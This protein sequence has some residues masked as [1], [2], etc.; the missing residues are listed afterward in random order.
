MAHCKHFFNIGIFNSPK[1]IFLNIIQKHKHK[2]VRRPMST[3]F[4]IKIYVKVIFLQHGLSAL[5]RRQM[6]H[7]R[8]RNLPEEQLR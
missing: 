1:V 3:D 5:R 2:K 4:S 7:G 6:S 8:D